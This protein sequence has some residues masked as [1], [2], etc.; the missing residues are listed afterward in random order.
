MEF[1]IILYGI[2]NAHTSYINSIAHFGQ[3]NALGQFDEMSIQFFTDGEN[4]PEHPSIH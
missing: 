1:E 2:S 3:F 4:F